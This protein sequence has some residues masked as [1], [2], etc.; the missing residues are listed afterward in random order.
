MEDCKFCGE[1][2]C[3]GCPLE[4]TDKKTY[5]ELMEGLKV[6]GNE[7]FFANDY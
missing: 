1:R 6:Q 7:S 5:E 3:E 2:K 4:Y